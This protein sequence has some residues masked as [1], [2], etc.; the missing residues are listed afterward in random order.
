MLTETTTHDVVDLPDR[1]AIALLTLQ[2]RASLKEA[3][4]AEAEAARWDLDAART[5]LA[6]R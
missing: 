1:A 4:E 3:A 2:L 6:A 5:Q